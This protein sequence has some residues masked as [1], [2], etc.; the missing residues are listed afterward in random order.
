MNT[1]CY[2]TDL[3]AVKVESSLER[4]CV[5]ALNTSNDAT[6]NVKCNIIWVISLDFCNNPIFS[7]IKPNVISHSY[8]L[9][10][11]IS[12]LSFKAEKEAAQAPQNAT[13][14]VFT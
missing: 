8:Y 7:P 9:C 6:Y 3:N 13:L 4:C 5:H 1:C 11:S 10:Q 14:L 2:P 12:V